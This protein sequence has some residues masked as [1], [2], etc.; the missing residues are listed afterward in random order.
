VS[1]LNGTYFHG[2]TLL[3]VPVLPQRANVKLRGWADA[4]SKAV[5]TL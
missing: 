1:N 5:I 4:N 2:L 3:L